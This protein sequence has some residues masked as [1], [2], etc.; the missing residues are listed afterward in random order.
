MRN[1]SRKA[2]T[3]IALLWAKPTA[4]MNLQ[5]LAFHSYLALSMT[6]SDPWPSQAG[7]TGRS[8]PCLIGKAR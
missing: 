6:P 4:L 5:P 2:L 1:S 7:I 8:V 3:P